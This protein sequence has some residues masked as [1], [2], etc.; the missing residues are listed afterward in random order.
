MDKCTKNTF[1]RLT[2]LKLEELVD[3][4]ELKD[5]VDN[6]AL[7]HVPILIACES[8]PSLDVRV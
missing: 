6:P 7:H 4:E 8:D 1:A 5:Y 3:L 2:K